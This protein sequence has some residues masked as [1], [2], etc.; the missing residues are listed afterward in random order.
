MC[1][2]ARDLRGEFEHLHEVALGVEPRERSHE[3]EGITRAGA[4]GGALV[5]VV[6]PGSVACDRDAARLL[7]ASR[8]DREPVLRAA[9]AELLSEVREDVDRLHRGAYVGGVEPRGVAG[10]VG[11]GRGHGAPL[12]RGSTIGPS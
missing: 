4:A 12:M 2:D 9:R 5:P 1:L 7:A 11:D 6:D 8:T 3:V 10:A